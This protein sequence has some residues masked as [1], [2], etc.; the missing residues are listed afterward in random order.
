VTRPAE[1]PA[2]GLAPEADGQ[3]WHTLSTDRVLQAQGVDGR[4][5]L[6]AAEVT[7]RAQRFGPNK[8]AEAKAEPRWRAFM[9][10]YAD[11]MQIVL[12]VAGVLCLF[13]PGQLAAGILLL[14]LTVFNAALGLN[15]EGK[16]A[17]SVAALNK[18]LVV[19]GNGSFVTA[20]GDE[21]LHPPGRGIRSW[22][23][24][25]GDRLFGAQRA[26]TG[27]DRS[28]SSGGKETAWGNPAENG[29]AASRGIPGNSAW[30][31]A[32]W[33]SPKAERQPYG[34]VSNFVRQP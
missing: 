21:I 18:M 30:L 24:R 28:D 20:S 26:S 31:P 1:A 17:E 19:R 3:V 27:G 32:L 5:G 29:R 14:A 6:S 13:I 4:R 10:Q 16:A 34:N 9:R 23:T 25:A 22:S 2:S 12:L 8:F 7:A 33:E 11:P 15:Q